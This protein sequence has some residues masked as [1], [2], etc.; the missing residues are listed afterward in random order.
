MPELNGLIFKDDGE[1]K[2]NTI[3]WIL[4]IATEYNWPDSKWVLW[5]L[6][7]RNYEEGGWNYEEGRTIS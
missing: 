7:S 3:D 4:L 2:K 6:F 1:E 5:D